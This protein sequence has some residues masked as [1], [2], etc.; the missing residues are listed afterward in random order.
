[1]AHA[2][3][4]G[5][6]RDEVLADAFHRP[7]TGRAEQAAAAVFGHHRTDRVGQHHFQVRLHALEEARQPGQGAGR[8]DAD[9]DGVHIMLGLRPDLRR[10]AG[11]VGQRVGRVVELVGEEG[12]GDVPARRAATSW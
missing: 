3:Q 10:G 6:R 12:V 7:G 11:F 1:V 5:N 2:G 8:T 4:V 9:H